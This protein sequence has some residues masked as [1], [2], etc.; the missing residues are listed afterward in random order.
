MATFQDDQ[1]REHF[2]AL[3]SDLALELESF[4]ARNGLSVEEM[5]AEIVKF[6]A[7]NHPI[8]ETPAP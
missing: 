7:Q 2:L 3:D 5:V 4:A 6:Y 8:D 1:D